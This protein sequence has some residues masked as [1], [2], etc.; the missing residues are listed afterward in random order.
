MAPSGLR[1]PDDTPNP[2]GGTAPGPAAL[3][4]M[5]GGEGEEAPTPTP[6]G[7]AGPG[8]GMTAILGAA[9][10]TTQK[11]ELQVI[12]LARQFPAA[13]PSLQAAS[14]NLREAGKNLRAASQQI[15]TSPAQPEPPAPS[16]GG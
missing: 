4:G 9:Y 13:S 12:Q 8:G 3:A 14:L 10:Q 11:M 15:M 6:P 1:S 2:P 5:A 16:I 7:G